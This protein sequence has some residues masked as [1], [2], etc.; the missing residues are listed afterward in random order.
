MG[1]QEFYP[2][3]EKINKQKCLKCGSISG[4]PLLVNNFF[5][6]QSVISSSFSFSIPGQTSHSLKL[7]LG[8]GGLYIIFAKQLKYLCF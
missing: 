2:L 7:H 4:D 6:R 3:T 1:S 8:C 5:N